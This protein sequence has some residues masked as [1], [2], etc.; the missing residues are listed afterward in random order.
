M[1]KGLIWAVIVMS[2]TVTALDSL[3]GACQR[4]GGKLQIY[5]MPLE[6]QN[7]R[8]VRPFVWCV[9]DD[10]QPEKHPA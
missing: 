9:R 2:P 5:Q 1:I 4:D 6:I 7:A 3:A 8:L 10:E